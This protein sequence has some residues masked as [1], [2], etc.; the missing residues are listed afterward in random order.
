MQ[1][2]LN[3][4]E[5]LWE[6]VQDYLETRIELVRMKTA[7]KAAEMGA[8]LASRMIIGVAILLMIVVLNTGIAIWLGEIMGKMYYGFFIVAGFYLLIIML[9]IVFR[10]DIIKKPVKNIMIKKI[11]Q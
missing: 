5:S 1:D 10:S 2:Q 3:S 11:F 7:G 4:V 8:A 9:L 6:K